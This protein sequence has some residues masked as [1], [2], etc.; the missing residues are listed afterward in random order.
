MSSPVTK[1]TNH[2]A[3]LKADILGQFHDDPVA[4]AVCDVIGG[5]IQVLENLLYDF[6]TNIQLDNASGD[7]LDLIGKIVRAPR[8][9]HTD[10][11]YRAVL[12]V[13]IAAYNSDGGVDQILWIVQQ[14]IGITCE[15][16]NYPPAGYRLTYI[17]ASPISSQT[18]EDAGKV[19]EIATS[20]GVSYQ[21]SEGSSTGNGAFRF[22]SGPGFN[23]GKLGHRIV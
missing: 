19:M 14:L 17:T 3:R 1:I 9:G 15:W 22:N 4:L 7:I 20:A 23:Q 12:Q 21:L 18:A 6:L 11:E 8:R 16:R 5:E 13:W 2:A 10:D